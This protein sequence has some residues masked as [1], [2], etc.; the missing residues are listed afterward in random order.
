MRKIVRDY[1]ERG[2]NDLE[3]YREPKRKA[4]RSG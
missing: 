3:M 1:M 4:E 2:K